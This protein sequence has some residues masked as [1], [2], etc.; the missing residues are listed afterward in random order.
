[1]FLGGVFDLVAAAATAVLNIPMAPTFNRP[2]MVRTQT[3]MYW[4]L[5]QQTLYRQQS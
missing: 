1:M 4:C 5:Q 2:W 3:Q